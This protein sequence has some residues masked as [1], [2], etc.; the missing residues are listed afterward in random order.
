MRLQLRGRTAATPQARPS[1]RGAGERVGLG[2][3]LRRFLRSDTDQPAGSVAARR[4]R[5]QTGLLVGYLVLLV[6]GALAYNLPLLSRQ[7]AARDQAEREAVRISSLQRLTGELEQERN[8]HVELLLERE[9]RYRTLPSEADLPVAIEELR[10]LPA[11]SGGSAQGVNYSEPRWSGNS[12]QLQ[13]RSAFAGTWQQAL[14]YVAAMDALLPA[15]GVERL[16][17][18]LDGRPGRVSMDLAVAVAVL[19]ERPEGMPG[20]DGLG[21]WQRA[22]AAAGG[23]VANGLPFT[24]GAMVWHEAQTVG[25][26]LPEMRLAGLARQRDG[27]TLALLVYDGESQ[28]VRPGSRVGEVE[29]VAV[30]DDGVVISI[31]GRTYKLRV[32]Q[33]PEAW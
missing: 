33:E 15:S 21:A 2:E 4:R 29:V 32:G 24:P 28:L 20:W 23:V 19:R 3:R 11:L 27:A 1:R 6:A 18:R 16:S 13:T 10:Q 17:V 9:Q 12:G 31:A 5:L 26:G 14:S 25:I 8:R 7:A 30:Q 22:E